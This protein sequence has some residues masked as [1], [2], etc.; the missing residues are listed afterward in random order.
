M[1]RKEN[2]WDVK[3]GN[4][5]KS[6]PGHLTQVQ[7]RRKA[8]KARWGVPCKEKERRKNASGQKKTLIG[9]RALGGGALE[10]LEIRIF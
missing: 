2:R 6:V 4:L 10:I 5:A 1:T 8:R 9:I 3:K 7:K